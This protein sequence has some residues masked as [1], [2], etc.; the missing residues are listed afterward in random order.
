[1]AAMPSPQVVLPR[2]RTEASDKEV[3]KQVRKLLSDLLYAH[4]TAVERRRQMRHPYPQPVYLTPLDKDGIV[5]EGETIVAA[6][7]DLS[8][9]GI[10]F[11]HPAPLPSR[12]MIVSLQVGEG[13]WRAFVIE[14]NWNR[15]IRQSWYES[16]GRFLQ[17]VASPMDQEEHP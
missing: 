3:R 1:M 10:G 15:A 9:C 12:Q 5:L 14:V 2:E 4:D 7:K 11:Y 13:Q 17:S 8:E 6:G 16:G